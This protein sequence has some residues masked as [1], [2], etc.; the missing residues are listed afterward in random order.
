MQASSLARQS[1]NYGKRDRV[2][3]SVAPLVAIAIWQTAPT[4]REITH[5]YS[6]RT[7]GLYY[8]FITNV[9]IAQKSHRVYPDSLGPT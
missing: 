1:I 6:I 3:E 5:G 2:G 4:C 8:E 7:I 9:K